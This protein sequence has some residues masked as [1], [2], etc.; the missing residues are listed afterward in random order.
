MRIAGKVTMVIVALAAAT[1]LSA[2]ANSE[3]DSTKPPADGPTG[4]TSAPP[5]TSSTTSSPPATSSSSASS[6]APAGNEC[7]VDDIKVSG[8]PGAKPTITIPTTCKPP[9]TLLTKDLAPG[10]GP[11]ATA[12][13]TA[14]L[15]YLLETWSDQKIVDNSYDRGQPIPLQA[16]IGQAQV[17]VGWQQG[18]VGMKQGGRRLLVIPPALGYGDTGKPPVKPNETLVFVV[19]A[20]VVQ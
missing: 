5:K 14:T 18:L 11:A 15:D 17:I 2:C 16:P 3:Q 9:T 13:N 8:A 7:K 4:A 1:A 10:N 20:V 19:D 6:V 12:Q